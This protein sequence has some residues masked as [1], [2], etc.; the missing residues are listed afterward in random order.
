VLGGSSPT[1]DRDMRRASVTVLLTSGGSFADLLK[2]SQIAQQHSGDGRSDARMSENTGR[3]VPQNQI[4][5]K[6][7][8]TGRMPD[9][10]AFKLNDRGERDISFSILSSN[11]ADLNEAWR[12]WKRRCAATRCWPMWPP[13]GAL[14]RPEIQI[15]PR[16]E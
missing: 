14:P 2:L 6:S 7:S 5:A 8:E 9:V 10:R 4:E 12:G 3:T 13:K 15:T 1:G 16:R 11:E